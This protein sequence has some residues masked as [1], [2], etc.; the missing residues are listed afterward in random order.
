M[1]AEL[2]HADGWTD[3]HDEANSRFSPFCE[4][5]KQWMLKDIRLNAVFWINPAQDSDK[6]RYVVNTIM[7]LNVPQHAGNLF[8]SY[9]SSRDCYIG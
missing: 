3:R 4:G 9:F 1:G 8:A 6:W 5:P 2:F 7:N